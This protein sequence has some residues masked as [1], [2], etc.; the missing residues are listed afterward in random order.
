M[1]NS[2]IIEAL[3]KI[4]KWR[5]SEY[6]EDA[7]LTSGL[8]IER[9][10]ELIQGFPFKL[11]NELSE[12]YT[13]YYTNISLA[14][15]LCTFYSLTE[16]LDQCLQ[17]WILRELPDEVLNFSEPQGEYL[18]FFEGCFQDKLFKKVIAYYPHNWCKLPIFSGVCKEVYLIECNKQEADISPVWVRFIGGE[19]KIYASSLSSL[20]LTIAECYETG[21]YYTVFHEE[22]GEWEIEE[23]LE[24]VEVIFEKYNPLQ[25]NTWRSLYKN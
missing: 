17:H 13:R 16:S 19:P 6:P 1:N 5:K 4:I 12:L 8:T 2:N 18:H 3:E 20:M 24:K 21:A 15:G 14:P 11:P 7:Y 10:Q 22:Y 9:F 25:I 23:D